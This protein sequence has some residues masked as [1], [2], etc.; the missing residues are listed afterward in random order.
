VSDGSGTQ[1]QLPSLMAASASKAPLPVLADLCVYPGGLMFLQL[2]VA[3]LCHVWE[4]QQQA[5]A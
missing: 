1:V 4:G 5:G 3:S 2:P